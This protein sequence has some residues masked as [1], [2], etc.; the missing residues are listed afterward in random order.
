MDKEGEFFTREALK[1]LQ[2]IFERFDKNLSNCLEV[3][4]LNEF[5]SA[6]NGKPF[7]RE[8][9]DEIKEY[10]DCLAGNLTFKGF[11][12]MYHLQS[13]SE[14]EITVKDFIKMGYSEWK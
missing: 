4:E 14:P 10:F 11:C 3:E 9:K 12:E 13:I 7:S 2:E 8:E 5:A 1:V 6:C